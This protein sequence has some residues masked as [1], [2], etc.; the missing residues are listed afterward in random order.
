ML[1]RLR[2][3]ALAGINDQKNQVDSGQTGHHIFYK[4]FMPRYIYNAYTMT[5]RQIKIGKAQING[6][7]P[8]F[9]FFRRI[10]FNARQGLN[11]CR[12]SV[13]NM[14]GRTDN[15][16]CHKKLLCVCQ[17]NE[18]PDSYYKGNRVFYHLKF[19]YCTSSRKAY[20]HNTVYLQT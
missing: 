10:R 2:H 15:N 19:T 18:K 14:A 6:H 1:P 4:F 5:V 7:A 12:F 13:V 8:L 3:N 11:Q 9:F 20:S 17:I 16:I